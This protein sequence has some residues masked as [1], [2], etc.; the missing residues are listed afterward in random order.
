M[1][2]Q[3]IEDV[4]RDMAEFTARYGPDPPRMAGAHHL[5]P[6]SSTSTLP[7]YI[8]SI[9]GDSV[10]RHDQRR[11]VRVA[12]RSFEGV[13]RFSQPPQCWICND[14]ADFLHYPQECPRQG[15]ALAAEP[16]GVFGCVTLTPGCLGL[17]PRAPGQVGLFDGVQL[18]D[19]SMTGLGD[20]HGQPVL[21]EEQAAQK[22]VKP[23][24]GGG[25]EGAGH[26]GSST[27]VAPELL[28]HASKELARVGGIEKNARKLR[29]EQA[30]Q[31]YVKPGKGGGGEGAGH[32]GK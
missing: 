1:T 29:E 6:L 14:D 26:A 25:G 4:E 8:C 20:S 9:C 12:G 32:A 18:P 10:R 23:G 7:E 5:E 21:R 16:P 15:V 24:K 17:A 30:A 19:A 2:D 11:C 3:Q 13:R 31:E 28:E 22:Y 27:M